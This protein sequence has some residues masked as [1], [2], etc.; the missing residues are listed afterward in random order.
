MSVVNALHMA[1]ISGQSTRISSYVIAVYNGRK[2][3]LMIPVDPY[4]I[5][6]MTTGMEIMAGMTNR[7]KLYP[8]ITSMGTSAMVKCHHKG[9]S[10]LQILT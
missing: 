10:P 6:M 9:S 5:V 4:S 1:Y 7:L 2:W 8:E 3:L